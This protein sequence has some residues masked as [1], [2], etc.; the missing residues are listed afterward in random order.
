[1]TAYV[2]LIEEEPFPEDKSGPWVKIGYSKNPPEWRMDA[3]LTRGNPRNIRVVEAFVYETESIAREA[4]KLAHKYFEEHY[5]QKEWFNLS[6]E[7]IS[8]WFLENGAI[9][10]TAEN[11]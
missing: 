10:R 8:K 7:T 3:N 4:E 2:Y 1:M 6:V 9:K 11:E 5:H